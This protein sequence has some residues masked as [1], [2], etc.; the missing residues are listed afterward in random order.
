ME[1]IFCARE[2]VEKYEKKNKKL[3]MIFLDLKKA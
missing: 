2:L 1:P 3:D